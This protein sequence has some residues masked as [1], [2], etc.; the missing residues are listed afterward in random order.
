MLNKLAARLQLDRPGANMT[1]I[2]I[3][4]EF[5]V[6]KTNNTYEAAFY[7]TKGAQVEGVVFRPVRDNKRSKLGYSYAWIMTLS[8]VS[9]RVH[10]TYKNGVA[11]CLVSDLEYSRRKLKKIVKKISR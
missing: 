2:Q 5:I 8:H 10:E 9:K 3:D 7:M 1:K 4:D 11:Q 6:I